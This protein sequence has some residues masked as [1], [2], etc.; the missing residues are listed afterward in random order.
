M[1]TKTIELDIP[2]DVSVA[3]NES[4]Q[5]LKNQIKTAFAL[6][7]YQNEKLTLGKAAQLA[8]LSRFEFELVLAKNKIPVSNLTLEDV[9]ADLSKLKNI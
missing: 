3:I 7:L 1:E 4:E 6:A 9:E 5:E 2:A 8:G